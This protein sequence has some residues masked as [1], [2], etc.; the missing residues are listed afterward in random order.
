MPFGDKRPNPSVELL[1]RD[2]AAQSIQAVLPWVREGLGGNQRTSPMMFYDAFI[3]ATSWGGWLL[4][5]PKP[6]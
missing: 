2:I 5:I 1:R 4:P 3:E 6:S